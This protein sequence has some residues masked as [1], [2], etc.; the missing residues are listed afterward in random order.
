MSFK[1]L[2]CTADSSAESDSPE[3]ETIEANLP[4]DE[5]RYTDCLLETK[6]T[7]DSLQK[8]LLAI[9]R[10]AD[11]AEQEQG[12]NILYLALGFLTWHESES[13]SITR[14]SPLIL[15]PV[16]LVRN[17][18]TATFDI[19]CRP[20]QIVTNMSL[21]ERLKSD[22]GI[23]LPE[24]SDSEDWTIEGYFGQVHDCIQS[25]PRWSIDR[26]GMQL[27]FFSFAKLLMLNDLD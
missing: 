24:V 10:D 15:L 8:K 3:L 26:D 22:F 4:F 23:A 17:S 16:Q 12:V 14:H 20:D 1:A 13:S 9:A 18:S 6:L 25:K 7:A 11:T 2:L 19:S 21:Q 27:G 5:S